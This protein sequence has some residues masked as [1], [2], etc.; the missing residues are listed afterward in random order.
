[1]MAWRGRVGV[2]VVLNLGLGVPAAAQVDS[3]G[4][5]AA[6]SLAADLAR[7]LHELAA[8]SLRARTTPSRALDLTAEYI[9]AQFQ[10]LGLQPPKWWDTAPRNP[11]LQWYPIPRQRRFDYAASMITLVTRPSDGRGDEQMT[12]A[13]FTTTAYFAPDIG[14]PMVAEGLALSMDAFVSSGSSYAAV[15]AGP[16]TAATLEKAE[17]ADKLVIY[18][19][20]SDLDARGRQAVLAQLYAGSK[21]VIMVSDEDSTRFAAAVQAARQRFVTVAESFVRDPRGDDR[22]PWAVVV[23][24]EVVRG[25]LTAAGM[26]LTQLRAAR[27]SLVR[28]VPLTGGWLQPVAD[29]TAPV[30]PRTAPNVVALLEGS[31]SVL[32]KQIVIISA[33]MDRRGDRPAAADSDG[34]N[35]D[36]NAA[37]AAGLLALAHAFSQPDMRPRRSLLFL[38]L[39]GDASEW[40]GSRFFNT[41]ENRLQF[42]LGRRIDIVANFTLDRIG[43]PGN[44]SLTVDGIDDFERAPSPVWLAAAHPELGLVVRN[45]GSAAQPTGDHFPF[46]QYA[47]PSLYFHQALVGGQQA[48]DIERAA[49]ML[50]LVFYVSQEFANAPKTLRWTRDTRRAVLGR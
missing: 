36:D 15:V 18:V 28:E 38:G 47:V 23:W 19:P 9:A 50:Q 42:E 49:R 43:Q 8:D 39:S 26:D 22:W 37:G 3:Q 41:P 21:G 2:L 35:A 13:N 25:A 7:H 29:T 12:Q 27:S 32:K 40:W 30:Q 33:R 1:M 44:D 24:P 34:R 11:W 4:P 46:V 20:P 31:D 16:Q 6:T 5:T 14:V 17:L 10:K 48:P 45:G